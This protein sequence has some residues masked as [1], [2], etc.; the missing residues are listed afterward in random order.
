MPLAF[1]TRPPPVGRVVLTL[2]RG[3]PLRAPWRMGQRVARHQAPNDHKQ[4]PSRPRRASAFLEAEFAAPCRQDSEQSVATLVPGSA[5]CDE[6][7]RGLQLDERCLDASQLLLELRN[8]RVLGCGALILG[9]DLRRL[10]CHHLL[11]LLHLIE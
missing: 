8:L 11:L 10:S 7:I 2:R 5:P 9:S 3:A 6:L 4:A 1:A